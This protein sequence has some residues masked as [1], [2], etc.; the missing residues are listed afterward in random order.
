MFCGH[1]EHQQGHTSQPNDTHLP[2]NVKKETLLVHI[3]CCCILWRTTNTCYKGK[4]KKSLVL[5]PWGV[6]NSTLG[7]DRGGGNWIVNFTPQPLYLWRR[8]HQ[9][10]LH[11]RLGTTHRVALDI[12]DKKKLLSLQVIEPR[13]DKPAAWACCKHPCNIFRFVAVKDSHYLSSHDLL[14]MNILKTLFFCPDS[15]LAR[16]R[17]WGFR[18]AGIWRCDTR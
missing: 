10:S 2:T 3:H 14:L 7:L 17:G 1:P 15:E 5:T 8:S 9:N 12:L 13:T 18:S 6:Y 11:R 16:R 4:L